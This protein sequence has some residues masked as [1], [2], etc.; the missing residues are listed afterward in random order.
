MPVS[1]VEAL[2]CGLPVVST[3]VTGIPEAVT[4][5]Y[6]GMLVPESDPVALAE[7][8]RSL[9]TDPPKYEAMRYN[10]RESVENQFNLLSSAKELNELFHWSIAQSSDAEQLASES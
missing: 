5:G 4:D 1:I 7:A 6:N 10:A 8:I 3:P 9:I 2:A